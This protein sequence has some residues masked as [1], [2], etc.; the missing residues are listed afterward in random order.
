MP[1]IGAQGFAAHC[2]AAAKLASISARGLV[3]HR[4]GG[5]GQLPN[6][7]GVG[8]LDRDRPARA[9]L[10]WTPLLGCEVDGVD[11]YGSGLHQRPHAVGRLDTPLQCRGHTGGDLLLRGEQVVVLVVERAALADRD[12][13]VEGAQRLGAQR[14][15]VDHDHVDHDPAGEP[16]PR[17]SPGRAGRWRGSLGLGQIEQAGRVVHPRDSGRHTIG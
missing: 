12:G 17:P 8:D 4:A 16:L 7:R 3:G 1:V 9:D 10:R 5:H 2:Q 14:G 6:V 13:A 11:A 15:R